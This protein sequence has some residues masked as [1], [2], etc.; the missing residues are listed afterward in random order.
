MNRK[1][2]TQPAPAVGA[3][4]DQIPSP[5]QGEGQGGGS[6]NPDWRYI[7]DTAETCYL[8]GKRADYHNNGWLDP[9]KPGADF[10]LCKRCMDRHR[11]ALLGHT[12][13]DQLRAALDA[14]KNPPPDPRPPTLDPQPPAPSDWPSPT[15]PVSVPIPVD[16]VDP[17]PEQP[18]QHFDE[19]ELKELAGNIQR[20]GLIQPIVVHSNGERFTL[21]DGE[22]RWRAHKLAGL[23]E[24]PAYIVPPGTDAKELLLRA[25]AANDQ[26]TD[27]TPI[28]RARSY[29]KLHDEY[30]LSDSD[31][32]EE[33]NKS[34]SVVANTRRLLSL[35]QDKQEQVASGE[36]NERQALALLPLCN[37][38]P[39]IQ[40]KVLGS[41]DG[42]KL[43]NPQNLTSDQIRSSVN[44]AI[45][46]Q[47]QEI[48]LI[49]AD[50]VFSGGGIHHPTCT[51]CDLYQKVGNQTICLNRA[52]LEAKQNQVIIAYLEEVK[53]AVGLDY[54]DPTVNY[55]Y[56]QTDRFYGGHD[57]PVLQLALEK[58]CPNLR[59]VFNR[60][61][62]DS[63]PRP[64]EFHRCH[65]ECFHDKAGC[66]CAGQNRAEA[67]AKKKAEEQATNQV[68]NQ[69][70]K[71]MVQVIKDN[72]PNVLRAILDTWLDNYYGGRNNVSTM[73]PDQVI[74]KLAE[75]LVERN[76]NPSAYRTPEE[77]QKNVDD[78]LAKMGLPAMGRDPLAD[79]ETRFT[80]IETW[81]A[82][83]GSSATPDH[84][85]AINGNLA[86]LATIAEELDQLKAESHIETPPELLARFD[87]A[88][89]TLLARRQEAES[90]ANQE[91]PVELNRQIAVVSQKLTEIRLWLNKPDE[92]TGQKLINRGLAAADLVYELD[93]L[94][95]QWAGIAPGQIDA[96]V[97]LSNLKAEANALEAEC[98]QRR[99][100]LNG[101]SATEPL[102]QEATA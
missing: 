102:P 19:A 20:R 64:G 32:A 23:V 36:L 27:L 66:A 74:R 38:P 41:Y 59:L 68:K 65:Y 79:L 99:R 1:K 57:S 71:H 13:A 85:N 80:R 75:Q 50:Q 72:H 11:A 4:T 14:L 30:G 87:A 89:A 54:L 98:T 82:G 6:A 44:A 83:P 31:I 47:G 33:V 100:E 76:A 95:H 77:N 94:I 45:R 16:L 5:S 43:A 21:H 101:N 18:R 37:L 17:N 84:L 34:R 2:S 56:N 63:G 73:K 92:H 90:Q 8:C 22:R 60:R 10:H 42:K 53:A 69:A 97:D 15:V 9:A 26:R 86:N 70:T 28:E 52:C 12:D 91:A 35:P 40:A 61:P 24:I 29:Q 81:I 7:P 49:E 55:E 58:S 46:G 78:W 96:A 88:K 3:Q 25:I 51:G 67:E 48:S 39:E 93:T 62:W